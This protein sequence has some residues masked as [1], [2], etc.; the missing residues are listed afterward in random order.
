M[1]LL[2][3]LFILFYFISFYLFRATPVAYGFSQSR[4]LIGAVAN[5]HSHSNARSEPTPQLI[6]TPDA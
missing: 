6:A 4:G 1:Y 2:V 3:N 5:G